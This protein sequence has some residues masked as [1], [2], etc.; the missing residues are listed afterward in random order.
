[1]IGEEPGLA[2]EVKK[3][4]QPPNDALSREFL[5]QRDKFLRESVIEE[6]AKIA[7]A[8]SNWDLPSIT[9]CKKTS[10][11]KGFYRAAVFIGRRIRA[12]S[13]SDRETGAAQ[14]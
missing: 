14:P 2:L 13:S 1:M 4:W 7:D 9:L 11:D 3:D 12:L 5:A 10:Y 6:C 8:L